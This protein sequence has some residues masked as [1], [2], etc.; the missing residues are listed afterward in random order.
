VPTGASRLGD[1]PSAAWRTTP[2]AAQLTEAPTSTSMTPRPKL[3]QVSAPNLPDY[4]YGR[5]GV[6]QRSRKIIGGR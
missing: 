3:D 5:R 1:D 2:S 4:P 6:E